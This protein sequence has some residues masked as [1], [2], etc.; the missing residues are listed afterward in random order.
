MAQ[1]RRMTEIDVPFAISLTDHEGWGNLP[2]DFRR[3]IALKPDG[4]FVACQRDEPVGIITTTAY[5]DYAFM[6]SLIVRP[7]YRG[8]GI[9]ETLM[10]RAMKHLE[11]QDVACIELDGT[12]AAA[13]LYRRLGF[14]DKY[15]SMRF[16]RNP[17]TRAAPYTQ[18]ARKAR[19]PAASETVINLDA[20]F[21]G[22]DRRAILAR[23]AGEF[24]DSIYLDAI[25]SGG[26]AFVYP[27][28][29]RRVAIGPLVAED[30]SI[31][32]SLLDDVIGDYADLEIAIGVS[33]PNDDAVALL[34]SRG[35]VHKPPSLRMYRGLR[36]DYERF[37]F[38]II[39]P[40]KG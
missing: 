19:A 40:E 35:F 5:G 25:S 24:P 18:P 6:G 34:M 14:L 31:A 22:L 30:I 23:F 11:S 38:G 4:C 17:D 8:H 29:G 33:Q 13:P 21:T 27:R 28:V 7:D 9:G 39:S 3:L 1:I 16:K 12:F 20:H 36:R 15:L 2:A 32:G 26:Y 10:R 37:I